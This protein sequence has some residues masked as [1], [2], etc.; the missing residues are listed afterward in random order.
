MIRTV[1]IEDE[2]LVRS[3]IRNL[4]K[5]N[6][7]D[8]EVVGEADGVETGLKMILQTHPDLVLLDVKMEDGSGFD[9]IRQYQG[10]PFKVIFITAY[11]EFAIRAIKLSAVD[12]ILKPI[13][14]EELKKAIEKTGQL[15]AADYDMKVR[16]LLGNINNPSN[17]DK[18]IVLRTQEK[19][20]YINV[21][22]I[23]YCESDSSY[24]KFFL[25]DKTM[26]MVSRTLKEFEEILAGY[27]FYRLQKSFLINL[28]QIKAYEKSDGGCIILSDNSKVPISE[29][30]KEEFLRIMEKL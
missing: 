28:R 15:L 14:P 12:Y 8:A 3:L 23:L 10:D 25:Y 5:E 20:H 29:K 2:T 16:T 17:G 26:I 24:T 13:S 21:H 1:I 22:D 30:K 7:H 4:L 18:K 11:E 27:G 19:Y 6:C 9:L